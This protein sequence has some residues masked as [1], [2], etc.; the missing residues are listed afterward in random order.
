MAIQTV[1]PISATRILAMEC[2]HYFKNKYILPYD[3]EKDI[4]NIILLLGKFVHRVIEVYHRNI[5]SV[6]YDSDGEI[7]RQAYIKVWDENTLI[8]DSWH[9]I[10]YEHLL[11]FAV[12]NKLNLQTLWTIEKELALNWALEEVDWNAEDVWLRMKMDQVDVDGST[13]IITDYKS[14]RGWIPSEGK[15]RS[16]LQSLIYPFGMHVLNPSL[17]RFI[18]NYHFTFRNIQIPIEYSVD[19]ISDVEDKLK[20]FTLR[21][22]KKITNKDYPWEPQVGLVCPICNFEC[23]LTKKGIFPIRSIEEAK[24]VASEVIAIEKK[25]KTLKDDLSNFAKVSEEIIEIGVGMFHW[26]VSETWRGIKPDKVM[27]LCEEKQI[28]ELQFLKVDMDK[29]KASEWAG[30]FRKLASKVTPRSTFK[31]AKLVKEEAESIEEP[32]E[33]TTKT[34]GSQRPPIIHSH[35]P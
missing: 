22:M 24:V 21:T 29:I 30:D 28:D 31:F 8:P 32:K 17:D 13:A 9:D 34:E 26:E 33:E 27:E 4:R 12:N 20:G 5:A 2:P 15:L 11:R 18:V 6:G 3:K 23:P 7:F 16:S 35:R 10:M 14:G 1:F 25:L 19:E